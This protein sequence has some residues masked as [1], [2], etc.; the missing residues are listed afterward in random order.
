MEDGGR[1]GMISGGWVMTCFGLDGGDNRHW[2]GGSGRIVQ[3]CSQGRAWGWES[4]RIKISGAYLI[5]GQASL[6][7]VSINVYMSSCIIFCT[8]MEEQKM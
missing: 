6:Y 2:G 7:K 3:R 5:M 4:W 8:V 1:G